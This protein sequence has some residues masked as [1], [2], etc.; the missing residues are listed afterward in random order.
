MRPE[1]LILVGERIQDP[2]NVGVLIRT[3]DA[4]GCHLGVLGGHRAPL[5]QEPTR[6]LGEPAQTTTAT[7]C[8]AAATQQA[9]QSAATAGATAQQ[10]AEAAST[11]GATQETTEATATAAGTTTAAQQRAQEAAQA[12]LGLRRRLHP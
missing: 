6:H 8:A 9:T 4:A 12:R 2:R 3:A 7:G 1:A 11:T 10:T 5:V